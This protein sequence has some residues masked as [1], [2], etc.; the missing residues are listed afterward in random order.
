MALAAGLVLGIGLLIL[1]LRTVRGD[2]LARAFTDVNFTYL[3]LAALP[4]LLTFGVKVTRWGL[5]FGRDSPGWCTLFG[6][7][8][9]G[10]GVNTIVPLRLGEVVTAYW[11]RGRSEIGMA[12]ALGTIAVERVTDG[13]AVLLIL[14]VFAPTVAFPPALVAPTVIVGA[15]MVAGLAG[16][17]VVAVV[18]VPRDGVTTAILSRLENTPLRLILPV[19]GQAVGG[20][21]A[22]RDPVALTLYVCYTA[23]I[24]IS[25]SVLF[26]L[27]VRAFHINVPVSAGFLLTGVLF[28]GM[29]VPSSPGYLGVYDYLMVLTLGLYKIGHVPAIAAALASHF[30]NVVPVTVV[31]LLLLAHHGAGRVFRIAVA[32]D[33]GGQS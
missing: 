14:V 6:A 15:V 23:V 16:L 8:S 12:R 20:A 3:L 30:I 7:I 25:N 22:L 27:L 24:W 32:A 2:L 33:R 26:W 19:V 4:F 11:I 31:G 5:L 21:R 10:Y 18:S 13:V 1:L 17:T 28:L 9:V 29:A